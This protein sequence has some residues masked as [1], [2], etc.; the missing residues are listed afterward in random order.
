MMSE[1]SKRHSKF[2]SLIFILKLKMADDKN[3]HTIYVFLLSL[4]ALTTTSQQNYH[5]NQV[6]V[7]PNEMVGLSFI[8]V[9]SH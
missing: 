7:T 8:A 9:I 3:K 6:T 1:S 4:L 2:L 5:N